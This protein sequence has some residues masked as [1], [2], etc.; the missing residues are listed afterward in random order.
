EQ[1]HYQNPSLANIYLNPGFPSRYTLSPEAQEVVNLITETE[2]ETLAPRVPGKTLKGNKLTGKQFSRLSQVQG[3]ETAR[4]I[5]KL[6][7]T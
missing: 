5:R 2:D 6:S 7:G 3:E 1:K 4:R